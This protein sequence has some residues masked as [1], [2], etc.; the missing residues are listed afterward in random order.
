MTTETAESYLGRKAIQYKKSGK[1]LVLNECPSCGGKHKCSINNLTWLFQCFKCDF[2]G[3]EWR[4]K[5][6]FGDV[7]Q[8]PDIEEKVNITIDIE[9]VQNLKG[10]ESVIKAYQNA[11]QSDAASRAREYMQS[12]GISVKT[13]LACGVGWSECAPATDN[14]SEGGWLIIPSFVGWD[15]N[16]N[17]DYSKLAMIKARNIP[18]NKKQYVR[19]KGGFTR[20]FQPFRI[21]P[22]ETV[23]VTAGE[24]DCLSIIESGYTNTVATTAGEGAWN[25]AFTKQLEH[26]SRVIV[27]YDNDD[28]G[29]KGA[30]KVLDALGQHRC[31]I[32]Q[33]PKQFNDLNESLVSGWLKS[34][35]YKI[36]KCKI[37]VEKKIVRPSELF[38]SVFSNEFA[39]RGIQTGIKCLDELIGGF[40]AGEVTVVTGETGSGKSTFTSNLAVNMAKN[41]NAVLFMPLEIGAIRQTE[42]WILQL[43]GIKPEKMD[44]SEI[45]D[46]KFALDSLPLYL[47]QH[48]GD[49]SPEPLRNTV[50]FAK[51]ALGIRLLV[52]D[53]IHFGAASN[54]ENE[55]LGLDRIVHACADL[56]NEIGISVIIVAHPNNRGAYEHGDGRI[57]QMG[58]IKGSSA[59]KQVASLILSVWRPRDRDRKADAVNGKQRAIVYNLK[60]RNERAR[61]GAC[62]LLFDLKTSTYSDARTA[63][64]DLEISI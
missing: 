16:G 42:K 19:Q 7:Y 52:I 14:R 9:K 32:Y 49:L 29:R 51:Q 41:D 44:D 34:N 17:S 28:A 33:L 39:D 58:D 23:I 25:D 35:I 64:F 46:V 43:T 55:R 13:L 2:K 3:G 45:E 37:G 31:G 59:I 62:P 22:D 63:E 40:R 47:F 24:V 15:L 10:S 11:L 61:E 4:F 5:E 26:C 60:A 54:S 20:L 8:Q 36:V 57:V 6:L 1:E 18:P 50:A 56:A 48:H 53:H 30:Q 21:N 12:R 27:V 38:Y